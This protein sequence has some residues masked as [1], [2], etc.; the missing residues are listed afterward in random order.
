MIRPVKSED[1]PAIA[2]IYAP[3]VEDEVTSFELDA[4]DAS[5]MAERIRRTC[6]THPW[7]VAEDEDGRILGYAYGTVFRGRAAYR[8]AAETSVYLHPEAR[9]Q[10]IGFALSERLNELLVE[11]GFHLAIA[12]ITLPNDSSVRLH[13]RLGY[14]AAGSLPDVG[15]KFDEW[16]DVGLWV[17]RLN[18]ED[19][20]TER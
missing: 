7:I 8:F 5:E 9:G 20:S 11:R 1:A 16:H 10:G 19:P 2:A 13:E 6:R 4:P 12:V 14:V 15:R 17:L 18:D 3:M